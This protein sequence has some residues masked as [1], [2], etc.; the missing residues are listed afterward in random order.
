MKILFLLG[1]GAIFAT[2]ASAQ[3]QTQQPAKSAQGDVSITIYSDMA[4]VEDTRTMSLPAGVSRQEF[5]D[6]SASIRPETV[7]LGGDGVDVVEQNFDFDLLSPEKLMQKAEG[8]T[9]TLLRTNEATGTQTREPAKVL[10]VNGGVVMQVAD[11]VEILRDDGLPVRVLFDRIPS[12]LR[13]RPTLSVTMESAKAGA[14][15]LTLSY[16]TSGLGWNADYVGLFDEAKGQ[17]NIQGWVTLTNSTGT[18]FQN[19]RLSLAAGDLLKLQQRPVQQNYGYSRQ[20]QGQADDETRVGDLYL[21]PV[22]GRT[23]IATNQKKQIS[24]LDV[25]GRSFQKL[26]IYLQLALPAGRADEHRECVALFYGDEGRAS[27]CAPGGY[28]TRLYARP[29]R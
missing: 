10:A 28:G 7:T 19:A 8:Q 14:R 4:L 22:E 13:A 20:Q 21:Y 5:A 23:T 18:A 24:F 27:S 11:H 1:A 6:V 29:I 25:S 16:L 17:M 9:I 3:A 2:A 12:N 15:P 26:P